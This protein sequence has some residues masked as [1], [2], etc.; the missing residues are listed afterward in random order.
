M[1]TAEQRIWLD[2]TTGVSSVWRFPEDAPAGGDCLIL[3]HGAGNDMHSPFISHLQRA[4]ASRGVITVKFNFP[5]KEQGRVAPDRAPRLEQTF[6]A[7]I[8]AVQADPG[9]R[10]QQLFI[11]GKSMGGRIASQLAA[12]DLPVAG[13]VLLGY[14]L[15]PAGRPEQL[16]AA[17][18][19]RIT[20]PMLFIQ[21]SR[22]R[23]CDLDLLRQTLGTV[24]APVTLHVITDGD[25]SFKVPK[26][27]GRTETAIWDE[28]AEVLLDWMARI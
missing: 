24:R 23:L 5:Y 21:G 9:R 4:I 26:R 18:L 15:H 25:H 16:R 27:A 3:A 28:I 10:P 14:P 11:G 12:Q 6:R 7:V 22:D 2:P 13:L 20:C 19:G 8:E 1:I 17:H